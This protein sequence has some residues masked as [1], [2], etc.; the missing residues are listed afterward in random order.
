MRD[1]VKVLLITILLSSSL[2]AQ[3]VDRRLLGK[4]RSDAKKTMQFNREH[5]RLEAGQIDALEQIF[6]KLTLEITKTHF[7]A[8]LP[9]QSITRN[10]E[11][12]ELD[13]TRQTVPYTVIGRTSEAVATKTTYQDPDQLDELAIWHFEGDSMWTYVGDSPFGWLHVREYFTKEG[14]N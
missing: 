7:Y 1:A 5:A 9:A 14:P 4:W 12:I 13:A 10:G 2:I 3:D 8:E 11:T 6:G